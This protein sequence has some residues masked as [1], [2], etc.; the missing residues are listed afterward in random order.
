MSG[1]IV[2]HIFSSVSLYPALSPWRAPKIGFDWLFR[3]K[4]IGATNHFEAGGFI[5]SNDTVTYPNLQF[6]F[7]PLAIRYDGTAPSVDIQN[8]PTTVNSTATFNVTF[9][10]SEDVT[11]FVLGDIEVVNG[12]AGAF[13]AVDGNTYTADITPN[14]VGTITIDVAAGVAL[15]AAGNTSLAASQANIVLDDLGGDNSTIS[16]SS[17]SS[18][19]SG[20]ISIYLL[21]TL[22]MIWLMRRLS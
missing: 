8:E 21:F 13:V 15:D 17:G 4:G 22:G 14:G 6:H 1:L 16:S 5:R 9:E 20:S 19:S 12:S 11:G 10:F 18:G 2:G 7:L 3:K